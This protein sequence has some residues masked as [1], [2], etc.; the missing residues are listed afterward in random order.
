MSASEDTLIRTVRDEYGAG[1]AAGYRAD[2]KLGTILKKEGL[3]SLDD[4]LKH[5]RR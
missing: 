2:T 3:K 1:V 5:R 4:L